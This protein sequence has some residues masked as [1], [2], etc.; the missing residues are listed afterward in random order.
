[1]AQPVVRKRKMCG[2]RKEKMEQL[3]K[4]IKFIDDIVYGRFTKEVGDAWLRIRAAVRREN[5]A[6]AQLPQGKICRHPRSRYFHEDDG[7]IICTK[8]NMVIGIWRKSDKL[9]PC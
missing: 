1:M 5:S 6:S 4:D 8:C 7:S 9:S 3:E 2:A